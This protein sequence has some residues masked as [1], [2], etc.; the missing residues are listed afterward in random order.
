MKII[1]LGGNGPT[2]ISWLEGMK[3]ALKKEH[4]DV[5]LH[6]Y[7][8]WDT[9]APL[10][11]FDK[12]IENLRK[13]LEGITQY[14]IVAKSAGALLTLRGVHERKLT[15]AACVFIGIA[16]LWGREK[17]FNVDGWLNNYLVPTLFIHKSGDPAIAPN[18]LKIL[19]KESGAQNYKLNVIPGNEHEYSEYQVLVQVI[20]AFLEE[21]KFTNY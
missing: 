13:E 19:L 14:V 11:D 10:I 9:N 5:F 18:A 6:R 2:N 17:N 4:S 20:N 7:L 8:H 12:E 16:I 1:L 3:A 21:R 15:P